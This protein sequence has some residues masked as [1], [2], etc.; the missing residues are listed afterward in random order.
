VT[1]LAKLFLKKLQK[2]A[3]FTCKS[4]LFSGAEKRT[5]RDIHPNP[6]LSPILE[7]LN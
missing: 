6:N 2:H 1:D 7:R 4:V 3:G 5:K